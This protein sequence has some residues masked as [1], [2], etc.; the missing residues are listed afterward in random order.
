MEP[1][2]L[3]PHD[4]GLAFPEKGTSGLGEC[5]VLRPHGK[6]RR[7][8]PVGKSSRAS[9]PAAPPGLSPLPSVCPTQVQV[10]ADLGSGRTQLCVTLRCQSFIPLLPCATQA[11]RSL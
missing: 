9:A 3:K 6:K 2:R 10:A 7:G 5:V 11:S 4:V 1:L 8:L